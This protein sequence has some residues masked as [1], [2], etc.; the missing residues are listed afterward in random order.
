MCTV[1]YRTI[2]PG[3]DEGDG[4]IGIF[5]GHPGSHS[6]YANQLSHMYSCAGGIYR[7][8]LDIGTMWS[9]VGAAKGRADVT[10]HGAELLGVAPK[11]RAAIQVCEPLCV[12]RLIISVCIS[13]ER[14]SSVR[15]HR[16]A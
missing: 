10:A 16:V 8:L 4:F 3:L 13:L 7:G 9:Q 2:A 11:L 6:G 1:R 15:L 5:A 14:D 12:H